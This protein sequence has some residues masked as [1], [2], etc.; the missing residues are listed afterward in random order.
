MMVWVVI[1]VGA[2]LLNVFILRKNTENLVQTSSEAFFRMLVTVLQWNAEHGQVYVPVTEDM[3]PNPHLIN[4]QHEIIKNFEDTLTLVNPAFMTRQIAKLAEKRKI[5][6]FHI[7][8][9]NPLRPENK[10]EEWETNVLQSFRNSDDR[11]FGKIK[12]GDSITFKF[13]APLFTNKSC[14]S[15]HATQGHK[16][17]DLRGGISINTSYHDDHITYN[18]TSSHKLITIY[19]IFLIVGF[20][21]LFCI[22]TLSKRNRLAVETKHKELQDL[23]AAKDKFISIVAHDLKTPAANIELL[24]ETL[25][26]RFDDLSEEERRSCIDMLV[27]SAKTHTELLNTLLDLSRLRLGS[28]N[29]DPERLDTRKIAT[30]VLEQTKL[31]AQQKQIIQKNQADE[32]FVMADK[33]MITAVIRNLVVNGIKFTHP[34]G[35]IMINTDR[36]GH[37]VIVSITDTGI[38]ITDA[39]KNRIFGVDSSKSTTGTANETGTGLGL[40]LCKEY[41]ERHN[42]KIWLESEVGKGT[43]F[44]F[45][46]PAL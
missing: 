15:C 3:R 26:A 32:F 11:F 23:N 29:Y 34:G 25:S 36:T 7:T 44:F 45:T 43:T 31:Q 5:T 21:L 4:S 14:L 39:K 35:Q 30:E 22:E 6:N 9:L 10:S 19:S 8:S 24:S 16:T 1:I 20:F 2:F 33:N 18:Y 40:L 37:D 17:G 13:M 38:G 27:E 42:G 41:V 12:S 28:K 46:L